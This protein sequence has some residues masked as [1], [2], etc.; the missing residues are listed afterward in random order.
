MLQV[1]PSS[2]LARLLSDGDTKTAAPARASSLAF[3]WHRKPLRRGTRGGSAE[4][5]AHVEQR[6]L[7]RVVRKQ[8]ARAASLQHGRQLALLR[9][10][11]TRRDRRDGGERQAAG[12]AG[13]SAASAAAPLAE[14]AEEG[15]PARR[16]QGELPC[17]APR[18]RGAP[19]FGAMR[20]S[21]LV[22]CRWAFVGFVA[23]RRGRLELSL[24]RRRAVAWSWLT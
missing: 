12:S 9:L 20:A 5:A 24:C 18:E 10:R 17:G 1:K 22:R 3:P 16:L 4:A 23:S 14:P 11:A 19:G 6:R 8:A 7:A 15:A 2:Q 21:H 13:S